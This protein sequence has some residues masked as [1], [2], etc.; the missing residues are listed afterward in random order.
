MKI[1]IALLL[2]FALFISSTFAGRHGKGY[3]YGHGFGIGSRP[4]HGRYQ[5]GLGIY[6][7]YSANN[8]GHGGYARGFGGRYNPIG[9]GRSHSFGKIHGRGFGYD[10][11]HDEFGYH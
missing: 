11:I 6:G 7:R 9:Y 3:G 10:S 1:F 4:Y 2:I 8:F 5:G